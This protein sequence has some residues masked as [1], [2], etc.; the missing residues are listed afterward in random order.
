MILISIYTII[1]YNF[2]QLTIIGNINNSNN[3][4]NNSSGLNLNT[5]NN[6]NGLTF[7]NNNNNSSNQQQQSPQTISTV[8]IKNFSKK[9]FAFS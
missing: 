9:M 5:N 3:N 7:T 1:S 6:S 8:L 2:G 4:V